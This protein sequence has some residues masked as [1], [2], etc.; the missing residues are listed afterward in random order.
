LD[1][2]DLV[3]GV[4]RADKSGD[5][6]TDFF[7][8]AR[9]IRENESLLSAVLRENEASVGERVPLPGDVVIC[10][11][12]EGWVSVEAVSA[13]PGYEQLTLQSAAA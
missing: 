5:L 10:L 8:M 7:W 3:Q 12:E 9:K 11:T 1:K 6:R 13:A 4:S 2:R